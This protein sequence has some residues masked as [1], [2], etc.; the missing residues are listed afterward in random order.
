[1]NTGRLHLMQEVQSERDR[2]MQGVVRG[3]CSEAALDGSLHDV[4][5]NQVDEASEG[6]AKY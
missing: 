6:R 5:G 3:D 2:R 1:M 4:F